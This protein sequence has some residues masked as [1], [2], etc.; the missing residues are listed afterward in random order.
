VELKKRAVKGFSIEGGG[1]GIPRERLRGGGVGH[2]L[3]W[4]LENRRPNEDARTLF[5]EK[6]VGKILQDK[7]ASAYPRKKERERRFFCTM[8]KCSEKEIAFF[9]GRDGGE[10]KRGG[11]RLDGGRETPDVV[12]IGGRG[13]LS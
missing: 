4:K 6:E 12:E 9:Q 5:K 1:K 11:R 8:W 2:Q 10:M 3:L 13:E 7:D